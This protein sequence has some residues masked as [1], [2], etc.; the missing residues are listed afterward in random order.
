[1]AAIVRE[2][3]LAEQLLTDPSRAILA[4]MLKSP[5]Q[6]STTWPPVLGVFLRSLAPVRDGCAV[7]ESRSEIPAAT[8]NL[9]AGKQ[10]RLISDPF[11]APASG[12]AW[13]LP[14]CDQLPKVH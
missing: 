3:Q 11:S 2:F 10:N 13:A 5:P 7:G 9:Q 8:I 1:M 14:G 4:A 6:K 12:V